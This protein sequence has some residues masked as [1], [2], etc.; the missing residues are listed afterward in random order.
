MPCPHFKVTVRSRSKGRSAVAGAAYQSGESLFSE[1]DQKRKSYSEKRGVIY[2]QIMLPANAPPEYVDRQTLW[3]AVEAIENQ[4]NSQLSRDIIMALPKE[5]PEELYP[6]MV[7]EFCREHFVSKGMCADFA[8][9]NKGDGNPHAHIMLTLRSMDEQGNWLPKC[10]KVYDLDENGERIRLPSGRFKSHRV[11]VNDWNDR[12][13]CEKWRHGW[14][15]IQNRYLENAG[16]EERVD[17]RSYERQGIDQIPTVHMGPAVTQMERRGEKTMVGDLNREIKE[18]NVLRKAIRRILSNL[19]GWLKELDK[20]LAA[21]PELLPDE[22]NLLLI[23]QEFME[24]RKG[25]RTHLGQK[26]QNELLSSDL[27]KYAE[28]LITME[29]HGLTSIASLGEHLDRLSDQAKSLD[30]RSK[31]IGCRIRD[32]DAVINAAAVKEELKPLHDQFTSIGWKSRKEKF[33]ADHAAELDQYKKAERLLRKLNV[34]LPIDEKSLRLEQKQLQKE[35]EEVIM[36]LKSVKEELDKLKLIR[37]CVRQVIPEALPTV[38]DGKKSVLEDLEAKQRRT[39]LEQA[40]KQEE[41][42]KDQPSGKL[43][44]EH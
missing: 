30:S 12:G 4:W 33:A 36:Q 42:A 16:R 20:K 10:R 29:Q 31:K 9:H 39:E 27:K 5:V 26:K 41:T 22:E 8:V 34:T 13:N 40:T 3:N 32:I 44:I 38:I 35:N 14:E 1:Y 19:R 17:L 11:N 43:R 28:A 25:D 23:L 7:R 15:V 2:T 37:W 24:V 6:Q 18:A 21:Q